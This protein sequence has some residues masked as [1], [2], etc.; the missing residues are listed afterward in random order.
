MQLFHKIIFSLLAVF[1]LSITSTSH[2]IENEVDLKS[3][4]VL[5]NNHV[6][7]SL[8]PENRIT[9]EF[10]SIP[11]LS[12]DLTLEEIRQLRSN[13]SIKMISIEKPIT[14][15]STQS[16]DW[17]HEVIGVP[18]MQSASLTGNNVKI[19][20]LDTG[21]DQAHPDLHVTNGWNFIDN[22]NNYQDD[23]GHGT[24][25]AGII[26]SLDNS[27]GTLG[28]APKSSIYALKLLDSNGEGSTT[29]LAVAIDWAIQHELD[30]LNLSFAFNGSD[31]IITDLIDKAYKHNMLIVGAA[32]NEGVNSV[33]FPAK[34]PNVI[35][36]GAIDKKKR[37]ANFSNTGPQIEVTAPGVGIKSTYLNNQYKYMDGTSMATPYVTGYLAL[38]KER[39]PRKT[40]AELRTALRK[41]TEDL[42]VTGRDPNYGYGLIQSFIYKNNEQDVNKDALFFYADIEKIPVYDNRSG[43]LITVGYLEKDQIYPIERHYT[44][45]YQIHFGSYSAFVRKTNTTP[46]TSHNLKNLT[47][48]LS[49]MNRDFIAI[50]DTPVYDNTSGSLVPFGKIKEGTVFT[51]T[52]LY[53]SWIGINFGGREGYV[54]KS[55]I[56]LQFKSTDPFFKAHIGD[57]PI[58][59]NRSLDSAKLGSLK[60]GEVYKRLRDYGEW[61]EIQFGNSIGYIQKDHTEVTF[62]H[63]LKNLSNE[64]S[65]TGRTF[66]AN[67]DLAVYDNSSGQ[68]V[69]FAV[70]N[71]GQKLTVIKEYTSWLTI[72]ISDRTGY[73]RKSEVNL[74][75]KGSDS[76]FMALEN[77]PIY[78]KTSNGLQKVAV[79]SKGQVYPRTKGFT[80]WHE[81]QF[82]QGVAYVS[83]ENTILASSKQ[84]KNEARTIDYLG[85]SIQTTGEATV[86]DNSSGHLAPFAQFSENVTLSVVKEY[87]SW[88]EVVFANRSGFIS[89]ENTRLIFTDEVDY[90][91]ANVDTGIYVKG[92]SKLQHIGTIKKGQVFPIERHYTSWFAVS[93]NGK[94]AYIQKGKTSPV[95]TSPLKNE[96]IKS[97]QAVGTITMNTSSVVYDNTSGSLVPYATLSKSTKVNVT[98]VYSRWFKVE[99]A[100]RF[101][102]IRRSNA[103]FESE[104]DHY[105]SRKG[106]ESKQVLVV[107]AKSSR[108]IYAT[109]KTYEKINDTWRKTLT[110]NAVLGENGVSSNKREGDGKTPT[111]I[112]PLR[113]AFGTNTK[114]KN[115]TYP[116][117]KTT[118]DDYWVDDPNSSDYN[119]WMTYGGD[120][121]LKWNSYEKL[122][123]PLY[124]HA[125]MIG[126]NDSPIVKGEGSAIFLHVWRNSSSPTLGCVAIAESQL[127]NVLG[128]LSE[129]KHPYILIGTNDTIPTIFTE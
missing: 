32:G 121:S 99:V 46:L 9:H 68:L 7:E 13:S 30:I 16:S 67:Q 41:N 103:T 57:T 122:A 107:E 35:A 73:I 94:T 77:S 123:I 42:G 3:V 112:F 101:G 55:D 108:S 48:D 97:E 98:Q 78:K 66:V 74:G 20:I 70:L 6:D 129:E 29:N 49:T 2:A 90:F 85:L 11:A 75:F 14:I 100:G 65:E 24:H 63:T 25:V 127:V 56:K 105:L 80:D 8:I 125:V 87:S 84:L 118:N 86:Y 83:K 28:I 38:L 10:N 113:D 60:Q 26:A 43:S 124:R 104:F 54:R 91:K 59:S 115:V 102:Y 4:T 92:K 96:V 17:G 40:N 62:T 61:H 37:L 12:A 72:Q 71:K 119:K 110:T 51:L 33:A 128:R 34:D 19:G 5:F 117:I 88:Y 36:V 79:L 21:I 126:Y 1:A 64:K 106:I 27:F 15:T 44:S 47:K 116:Y 22:N 111:G 23:N 39:Y 69:P 95:Q 120:P 93:I 50:T 18:V 58:Y 53:T 109:L 76:H 82:N 89:K 114:P 52:D 81:I 31:P 45:W